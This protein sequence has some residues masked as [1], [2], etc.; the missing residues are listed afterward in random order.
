MSEIFRAGQEFTPHWNN[1]RPFM[2]GGLETISDPEFVLEQL[3]N[4]SNQLRIPSLVQPPVIYG[5]WVRD[6]LLGVQPED[7]DVRVSCL[8]LATKFIQSLKE[9]ERMIMLET[10]STVDTP[11]YSLVYQCFSMCIKTP[12]T[13]ELR[14]DISYSLA[15][16][17][18]EESLNHCDFTANNLQVNRSGTIS[19]RIKAWQIG[20]EISEADWLARCIRD[21]MQKKLVWMIPDRFSK[22]MGETEES[23]SEFM[24]KMRLRLQKMKSKGF[25]LTGEHLT[26]FR[27]VP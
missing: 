25:K 15:S 13:E 11:G 1:P 6:K 26:S 4:L 18:R 27:L 2:E 5:G 12:L 16:S 17:L 22:R 10:R 14:I 3:E 8:P 9:S 23:R 20:L 7:M 21:C 24:E 19:T